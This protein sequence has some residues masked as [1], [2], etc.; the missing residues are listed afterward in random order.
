MQHYHHVLSVMMQK[1]NYILSAS[2][3]TLRFFLAEKH[4]Q[5]VEERR[6]VVQKQTEHS[7]KNTTVTRNI[8]GADSLCGQVD[9]PVS[10]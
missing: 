7:D 4:Q 3:S 2:V 6:V 1:Q 5:D 10:D 8:H 9:L